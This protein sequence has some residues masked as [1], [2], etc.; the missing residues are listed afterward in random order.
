MGELLRHGVV[1]GWGLVAAPVKP[2]FLP[3]YRNYLADAPPTVGAQAVVSRSKKTSEAVR[4]G[5]SAQVLIA[6]VTSEFLS[7][8]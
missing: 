7:A 2:D 8:G 6:Y 5:R 1:A 3:V 4:R